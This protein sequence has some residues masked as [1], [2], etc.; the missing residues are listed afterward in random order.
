MHEH[1]NL[2]A[3]RRS[4]F[5]DRRGVVL[6]L[7]AFLIPAFLLMCALVI[8]TTYLRLARTEMKIANDAAAHAAGR[9]MSL[10][11]TTDDAIRVGKQVASYNTVVGSPYSVTDQ[12][13]VFGFS[14]RAG[15]GYGRYQFNGRSKASVDNGSQ[16]ANSVA[17]DGA[18]NVEVLVRAFPAFSHVN[19]L[20]RSIATQVDRDISI[21]LDRSGSMLWFKDQS[22]WN[23]VFRDLYVRGRITY[24]D[25]YYAY[26]GFSNA[27]HGNFDSYF[28]SRTWNA[29]S[30]DKNRSTNYRQVYDFCDD[31]KNVTSRAP[32]H[33]RWY[34]LDQ[35]VGAFFDVLD[36]TDQEEY[37]SMASFASN[38]RL[39]HSLTLNYSPIR[40][41]VRGIY[42][43]GSTAI[44]LGI[45]QA[46]P[47]I[48]TDSLARPFA[49]KTIVILTD[50]VNNVNPSPESVVNQMVQQYNITVHTVTFTTGADQTA[51]RTVANAG[52]GKHYHANDGSEL[53]PIFREI[54]NNLPT[55][56][57]Q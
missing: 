56:L 23:S 46:I 32:T 52:S 44:G 39:D 1:W 5:D 7:F 36:G 37:V 9:A 55:I 16:Q 25:Y 34:Y 31:L 4:R 35:G 8:N 51:M 49:A 18:S 57:T 28:S 43:D 33:S 10:Y 15:N 13:F 53:V 2:N 41:T 47:S 3:C 19:L 40:N 24:N 12:Q 27:D 50:G 14:T 42:P 21:V 20:S 30:A 6:P 48:M 22:Q 17:I 26:Y 38:S 11:Q 45:Q 54:A 29:L